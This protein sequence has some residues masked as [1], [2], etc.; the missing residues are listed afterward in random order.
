MIEKNYWKKKDFLKISK[1]CVTTYSISVIGS[2]TDGE[3]AGMIEY[4]FLPILT[5]VLKSKSTLEAT[6][7]SE[8]VLHQS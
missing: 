8:R 4:R 3:R 1:K 2:Y 5:A 6:L 7:T